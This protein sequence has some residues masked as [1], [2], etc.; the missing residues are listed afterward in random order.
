M[1]KVLLTVCFLA[2]STILSAQAPLPGTPKNFV[3]PEAKTLSL[4][5]GLTARIIPFGV[6]PKATIQFRIKTGNAHEAAD[7]IWLAD[8]TA[9]LLKEGA[10]KKTAAEIDRALAGMGGSLNIYTNSSYFVVSTEVLSDFTPAAIELLASLI[11]APTFPGSEVERIKT[12]LKRQLTVQLSQPQSQVQ[13]AFAK[14]IFGDHSYGRIFPTEA[15]INSYTAAEARAFWESQAG[16]LRTVVYVAGMFDEKPVRSAIQQSLKEFRA[17][18]AVSYESP[19]MN[20][21]RKTEI[22]D[23]PGAPQSTIM[24]GLPTID[25]TSPDYTKLALTN[26]LLG[27]SFNSRITTNIREDKGYTYSPTSM[28]AVQKGSGY[29][30][31]SADVTTAVTGESLKEIIKEIQRLQQENPTADEVKGIQNYAAGVFVL[32]NSAPAGIINQLSFID[33]HGLPQEYLTQRIQQFYKVTP[34]DMSEM[35]KK[36]IRPEDMTLIIVGDKAVL[37]NQLPAIAPKKE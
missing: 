28:L 12:N 16:A 1:K 6:I 34:A 26:S 7:K 30:A 33:L 27:G 17:G 29:W 25:P 20:T 3:L 21:E 19:K 32:Q 2:V 4:K 8:F 37:E 11:T 5:N 13:E 23:R 9:E 24:V 14:S 10:G 36:Y 31:E 18:P 35:T 22:I 15:M